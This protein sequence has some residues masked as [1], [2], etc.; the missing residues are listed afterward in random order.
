M[1]K[2]YGS[3][4]LALALAAVTIPIAVPVYASAISP[5]GQ[6]EA[7]VLYVDSDSLLEGQTGVT[8]GPAAFTVTAATPDAKKLKISL[9]GKKLPDRSFS[10]FAQ[11]ARTQFQLTPSVGWHQLAMTAIDAQGK[12]SQTRTYAFGV[13]QASELESSKSVTADGQM[14][15]GRFTEA[16]GSSAV[17][18]PVTV[19]PVRM[20][21]ISGTMTAIATTKT[22]NDGTWSVTLPALSPEL[23]KW[24]ADNDGVLNLQAIAEG[25]AKDP[26]TGGVREMT[27]VAAFSTGVA[28]AGKITEAAQAAQTSSVPTA[29]LLPIRRANELGPNT[30]PPVDAPTPKAPALTAEQASHLR[31]TSFDAAADQGD[32]TAA[33]RRIG[34]A[35][36]TNQPVEAATP[37]VQAELNAKSASPAAADQCYIVDTL[38]TRRM[39]GSTQYTVAIESHADADVTGTVGYNTTA[40]SSMSMGISYTHASSWSVNGNVYI[41]NSTGFSSGFSRGPHVSL[42]WKVPVLYGYYEIDQCKMISGVKTLVYRYNA[43]H[44]EKVAIPNGGATGAYGANVSS[45]DGYYGYRDAPYKSYVAAHSR[46]EVVKNN[47]KTNSAS[48]GAWGFSVTTTTSKSTT[49][50]QSITA[51]A[52][53]ARHYIFGYEPIG[54]NMKVFY[55]Y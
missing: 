46:F 32:E 3:S 12:R 19:Y 38:V 29:P 33:A 23:Q 55:S 49:R 11:R 21:G 24:A 34:D 51:G 2:L 35:D 36:Y 10:P 16:D 5:S 42:Q 14:V 27:G 37:E 18:L 9:D 52:S 45:Y 40:G 17:G 30:V 20:D 6:S 4:L 28:T 15:G 47:T 8:G 22:N 25:V 43:T 1:S 41:G 50:S 48:A 31:P 7:S 13:R 26:K 53:T 54:N 39:S 44:A